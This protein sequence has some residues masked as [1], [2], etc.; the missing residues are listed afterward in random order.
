MVPMMAM[1]SVLMNSR[2]K[3]EIAAACAKF[4]QWGLKLGKELAQH[5]LPELESADEPKLDH[6]SSTNALIRRYRELKRALRAE[7][8]GGAIA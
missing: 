3:F 5:I 7:E 1:A 4:D 6:D 2:P 8:L